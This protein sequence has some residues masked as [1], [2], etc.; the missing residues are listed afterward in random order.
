MLRAPPLLQTRV[1]TSYSTR[2]RTTVPS[3]AHPARATHP[4]ARAFTTTP[5]ALGKLTKLFTLKR[6]HPTEWTGPPGDEPL[7]L[8]HQSS[9]PP[10]LRLPPP[11]DP[12]RRTLAG[13]ID[14]GVS[15]AVGAAFYLALSSAG[16]PDPGAG[17]AW[18]AAGWWAVRDGV[19]S[20]GRRSFGKS[21]LGLELVY[22]DGRP[23]SRLHALLRSTPILLLPAAVGA[24]QL[25]DLIASLAVVFDGASVFFTQDARKLGDYAAGTRVVEEAPDR[26]GRIADADAADEMAALRGEIEEISPGVLKTRPDLDS[27]VVVQERLRA[28]GRE[29]AHPGK[30]AEAA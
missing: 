14:A 3:L 7:T 10:D 23:A 11:G 26:A 16:L 4:G 21:A 5:P 28:E 30:V 12:V 20:C 18:G 8:F 24:H 19:S 9:L 17:A 1:V 2:A 15:A 22:W 29:A 6:H 25:V 13:C 27:V